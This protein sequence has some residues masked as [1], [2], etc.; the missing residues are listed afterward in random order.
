[1]VETP[2]IW[3]VS[4]VRRIQKGTVENVHL[5]LSAERVFV[6]KIMA[7]KNLIYNHT[8][9]WRAA[10]TSSSENNLPRIKGTPSIWK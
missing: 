1:M 8:I 2:E 9:T 3:L 7:N 5:D 10:L 4:V 6:R